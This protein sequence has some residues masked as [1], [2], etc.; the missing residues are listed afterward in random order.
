MTLPSADSIGAEN[1]ARKPNGIALDSVSP[2]NALVRWSRMR[3]VHQSPERRVQIVKPAAA[4][5]GH[6]RIKRDYCLTMMKV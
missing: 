1:H 6:A 5:A 4:A 3:K 2:E